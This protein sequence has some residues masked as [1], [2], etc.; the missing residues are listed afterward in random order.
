MRQPQWFE[1]WNHPGAARRHA[2]KHNHGRAVVAAEVEYRL[3]HLLASGRYDTIHPDV[4]DELA[5]VVPVCET[6]IITMRRRE[7]RGG[8][9]R[10]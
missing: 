4:F 10:A 1:G 8:P 5:V 6:F 3:V 2:L 7:E 9:Y